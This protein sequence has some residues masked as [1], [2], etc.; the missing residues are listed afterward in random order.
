MTKNLG[1]RLAEWIMNS[2]PDMYEV[3]NPNG[4]TAVMETAHRDATAAGVE[5]TLAEFVAALRGMGLT[6]N[7]VRTMPPVFRLNLLAPTE[8]RRL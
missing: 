2:R 1:A 7:Q 8:A 3:T 5:C 4:H 6:V